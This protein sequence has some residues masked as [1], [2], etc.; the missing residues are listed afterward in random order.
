MKSTEKSIHQIINS[1]MELE[2]KGCHTAFF[3]YGNGMFRIR[4]FKGDVSVENIVYERTINTNVEQS[5]LDGIYKH[6]SNM[7]YYVTKTSFQCFKREFIKGEKVGE[8]QEIKPCFEFGENATSEM[9]ISGSGYFV[10]DLDNNLQ[11]YVDYNKISEM[12]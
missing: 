10:S 12:Q 2:A 1:L 6:V 5:E 3:E 11:Y 8:W 4:I 7:K 9:V